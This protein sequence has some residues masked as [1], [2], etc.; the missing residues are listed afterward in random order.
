[1]KKIAK[2]A[3]I[4]AL[5]LSV[6]LPALAQG[7]LIGTDALNERIEDIELDVR[8][9][10][11]RGEDAERFSPLGVAQ[12]W[13]GSL[14]LQA[15]AA[16]G[17]TDTGE[18]SLAG[19]LTYGV[20]EW[21]HTFGFAGEYGEAN[22]VKNEEKFFATYEGSRY[23]TETVYAFGVGRYEYDG[24]ATNEHDVFFGAG[25][26]V[27]VVNT[28]TVT[29]RVQGGPGVRYIE[30][31]VGP[32]QT[33]AAGI[34]SSRFFYKLTDTINLTND[35]DVLGSE[36]NTLVRNDF[37]VNFKVTNN[38]STRASVRTDYNSD[39]LPGFKNTD[40]TFG[41]ALVVGF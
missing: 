36:F 12:G 9:E 28:D 41:L 35:T 14:A 31:A 2:F 25:P 37:G 1:M 23:F 33:E 8:E 30:P 40:N 3:S 29:W 10:L 15:S 18:V 22:G 26:G 16:T 5:A 17:N 4:S 34:L 27:R 24:F 32:D 7:T 38:L 19:R 13:N 39:P 20:G 21:N 11:A 6:A